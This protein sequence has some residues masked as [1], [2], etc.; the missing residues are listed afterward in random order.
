MFGK[1][2]PLAGNIETWRLIGLGSIY[3]DPP[4]TLNWGY[5]VPNSG[6]LGPNRGLGRFRGLGC[7]VE[8][9]EA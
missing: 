4:C 9:L 6:Y 7:K 5:T 2:W 1:L 3:Q 8:G